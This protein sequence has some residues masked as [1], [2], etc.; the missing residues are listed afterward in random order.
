MINLSIMVFN[1]YFFI[2]EFIKSLSQKFRILKGVIY[3]KQVTERSERVLDVSGQ[4]SSPEF[5]Y[6]PTLR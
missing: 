2:L 6:F 1:K 4:I 3:I 5:K